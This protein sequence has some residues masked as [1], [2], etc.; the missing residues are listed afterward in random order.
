MAF[1]RINKKRQNFVILDKAFLQDV[2]LSWK[3]KG[4]LAY[5]L[6]L[7][8]DWR[9]SARELV[10]HASDGKDTLYN[11]LRELGSFGYILRESVRVS[12]RF[13][14]V[15][16]VVFE[17]PQKSEGDGQQ[18]L[19]RFNKRDLDFCVAKDSASQP[20]LESP[21]VQNN[22]FA[23]KQKVI[24]TAVADS[25]HPGFPDTVLPHTDSP[26]TVNPTL[27]SNDITKNNENKNKIT[28]QT[29]AEHSSI[30]AK[31]ERLDFSK[32][33]NAAAVFFEN[34]K[35]EET[36]QTK[37]KEEVREKKEAKDKPPGYD[38]QKSHAFAAAIENS[39]EKN[40]KC[41]TP[42]APPQP[43]TE[44]D[45][46]INRFLT[47]NQSDLL[48]RTVL[49]F[50]HEQGLVLHSPPKF[51]EVLEKCLL[52]RTTFTQA[53]NDFEKK[54]NTIKKAIRER[55]FRYADSQTVLR[56]GS[57]LS[58]SSLSSDETS[59]QAPSSDMKNV[60]NTTSTA[61]FDLFNKLE[62]AKKALY[63]QN[64]E[65]RS[66]KN[67]LSHPV[68]KDPAYLDAFREAIE[69]GANKIRLLQEEAK[70]LQD[71]LDALYRKD[72]E[73]SPASEVMPITPINKDHFV[74][75]FISNDFFLKNGERAYA[76]N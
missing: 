69:R 37:Q 41:E 47:K 11:A 15:N 27:L 59:S 39:D 73:I 45:Q 22:D 56:Y 25:P 75:N 49:E 68:S 48:S 2:R 43:L 30:E 50:T 10:R 24:E 5:L 1:F 35:D 64:I 66:L 33:Q 42:I 6:S 8:D 57:L 38:S 58:S 70:L 55:R 72:D 7:P 71:Q 26:D 9:I 29:A 67:T 63:E 53:E 3:S 44:H 16:Y 74:N 61:V 28:K 18:Q 4:L 21:R 54:L 76:I 40:A 31:K 62:K 23:L 34:K 17:R 12:G 19:D 60:T 13:Q 20:L 32:T 46:I 51:R 36:K 52:D 65:Q 14:G